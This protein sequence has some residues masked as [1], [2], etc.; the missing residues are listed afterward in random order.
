MI[1]ILR[2]IDHTN[3]TTKQAVCRWLRKSK[4]T[5]T[6]WLSSATP[7]KTTIYIGGLF[8][9][10]E[11]PQAIWFSPGVETGAR[12]AVERINTDPRI[13]EKHE[14]ILLVQPTQC[15]RE[16]VM[17]AY[18][19]YLDQPNKKMI[20][21]IGPA[22]SRATMP[23]A[24][25]SKFRNTILMGYGASEVSFS[26][27]ERFPYYFRTVPTVSEFKRAYV[28]LFR[29]FGWRYCATLAESKYPQGTFSSRAEYFFTHG[30]DI[31]SSRVMPSDVPLNAAGYVKSLKESKVMVVLLYA[32]PE[33]TRE[34]LCEAYKQVWMCVRVGVCGRVRVRARAGACVNFVMTLDRIPVYVQ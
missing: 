29:L 23:L 21:V 15:R 2:G 14:L 16:L 1:E 31:V 25:V 8:P 9:S 34:V 13:L 22:C 27:R 24:E 4:E 10:R 5:L 19:T 17:N 11:E 20:G 18:I 6:S 33:F 12:M 32:Y 26:D 3:A 30:I 28:H 7:E